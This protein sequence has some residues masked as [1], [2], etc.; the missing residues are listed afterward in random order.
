LANGPVKAAVEVKLGTVT[1]VWA[2]VAEK[3]K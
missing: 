2:F 1:E 3:I